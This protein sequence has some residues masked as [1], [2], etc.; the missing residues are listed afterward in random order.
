MRRRCTRFVLTTLALMTIGAST[1]LGFWTSDGTAPVGRGVA[2]SVGDGATPSASKSGGDV[3]VAWASTTLSNAVAVD[4]Y[5]VKRYGAVTGTLA[6]IGAGCAVTITGVSCTELSA[7]VGSWRY[8]VT[9][10]YATN[11]QGVES[12]KSDAVTIGQPTI[13]LGGATSFAV[14][15]GSTVTSAGVS[16]LDGNLGVSPGTAATGFPPGTLNGTLH[17]NDGVAVQA[18]ADLLTAYDAAVARTPATPM[19]GDLGGLTLTPGTYQ[20]GAS[21]T[22]ASGLTLD[23]QGDPGA[24]FLFQAGSTLITAAGS[25]VDLINGASACNVFWQVGSSA[26]LGASS[27]LAGTIMALTSISMGD[28][29]TVNGRALA[30]NGAV[31]LINDTVT[32]PPACSGD[33]TPPSGGSVSYTEGYITAA[34]AS[35]TFTPGTDAGSGLASGS[36][37]LQRASATLSGGSCGTFGAFAT[38]VTDPASPTASGLT[39]GDCYQYRYLISDV[40]GNQATYTNDGVIIKADSV[41]PASVFSITSPIG[42]AFDS[43]GLTLYY[44]GDAAGSFTLV[45]TVSDAASGPASVVFPAIATAGWVHNAETVSTPTGGPYA[46]T[47]FSWSAGPTNPASQTITVNDA[48]GNG[49]THSI[50]FASDT[51]APAGGTISYTDGVLNTLSVP[52]TT[53]AATDAA[54][55]VSPTSTIKRDVAPL[56]TLTE[57]C[58]TFPGTFAT[59]VTLVAGADTSVATGNCYQYVHIVTDRVGNQATF[60]SA[61]VAK[62]DTSGPG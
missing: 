49:A 14:L 60:T 44:K 34:T 62:V 58:G 24:V 13:A 28:G 43:G 17:S 47:S 27:G 16:T 61:S 20:F 23:A 10:V 40:A 51:T 9:P 39:S 29:V 19:A 21:I 37:L 25:H 5:L 59:T 53:T 11:W 32:V 22:L 31:T 1:A 2:A 26:T 35:I 33:T 4:G 3:L 6:T 38:V 30:L 41:A 56:T 42:A 36:G 18:Q 45:D 52:V 12:A 50:S 8:T 15:G 48:A 55:G 46:S 54:S 57:T 7:P